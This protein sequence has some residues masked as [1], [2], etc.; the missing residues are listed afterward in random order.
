MDADASTLALDTG[1]TVPYVTHGA[2]DGATIVLLHGWAESM[3]VFGRLM[4]LLPQHLHA[5]AFDLRGHGGATKPLSGYSLEVMADDVRAFLDAVG[6]AS[7]VLLGSSSGG[8]VAQQV[9]VSTPDRV[10]GLVLVGSPRSL[11][12][13][14]SFADDVDALTDPIDAA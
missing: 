3:G 6:V 12:S 5:F 9:A 13:R 7:A 8:Y 11:R 2:A 10:E 14:P 4:P 1:I